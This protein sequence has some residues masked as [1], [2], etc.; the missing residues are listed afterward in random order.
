MRRNSGL[1]KYN[2]FAGNTPRVLLSL[3]LLMTA[4]PSFGAELSIQFETI[5]RTNVT[6]I[7]E[8]FGA[9]GG[10]SEAPVIDSEGNIAFVGGGGF[11]AN[12]NLQSGI[13]TLTDGQFQ[14]VADKNTLVPGGGGTKFTTFYGSDLN[15]IDAGRV[16]FRAN[17]VSSGTLLGIYSNAGQASPA[18]LVELALIDGTEWTESSHP[19]ID[20]NVVA[21]RG[22]SPDEQTEM[23]HWDGSSLSTS[24][25][26]PGT[27][28]IIS[29]ASQASISGD[30]TIFRRYK[31]GSSQMVISHAGSIEALATLDSTAIPGQ[32]G[33]VFSNFNFFPVVGNGGQDAAFRGRGGGVIGVY[34]RTNDGALEA[35]ADS[36][37]VAPGTANNAF[38]YFDDSGISLAGGQ[39]VFLG[40]GSSFLDGLYTDIGGGLSLI[41]DDQN[42]N[43]ISLDGQLEQVSDIRFSSKS[44]ADTP[45][46]YQVVFR[47]ALQSGGTAII[48]ATINTGTT[49]SAP[50]ITV[51]GSGSF[52]S[53]EIGS[54]STHTM[55]VGN[56]GDANLV[57]GNLYGLAAPF[58]I[59]SDGCSGATVAPGSTCGISVRFRPT[60]TAT[61]ADT[62]FIPSNDPDQ[63]T[64]NANFNGNG[65]SAPVPDIAVSG[66][67]SFGNVEIGSSATQ[68]LTV[69][70]AGDANLVIG[71]LFGLAA[72]FTIMTDSCTGRTL[73]P[74][75][76]CGIS[77]QFTPTTTATS[78]DT[79]VIP[80]NDPVEANFTASYSGSGTSAPVPDI[81]VS[82][83]GAMGDV[84]IGSSATQSLTISNAGDAN[85]VIDNLYGLVA[86]FS[87]VSD[88]CSGTTLT[89]AGSCT[90]SVRFAPSVTGLLSDTLV[91]PSNDP[92]QANYF[93]AFNGRGTAALVPDITVSGNG[94]FGNVEIGTSRT[95]SLTVSSSGTANLVIGNVYGLANPFTI[96]SD[97]CTGMTLAPSTSCGIS[98]LYTPTTPSTSTDTLV[99]PSNDPIEVS[100]NVAFNGT[101]TNAPEP[102]ISVSG[103]S[104]FGDVETGTSSNRSFTISNTGDANLVIDN[105]YGLAAPFSRV[106]DNCTGQTLAPAASCTLGVRFAPTSNG[107]QNDT[108]MIPSNDPVQNTVN[109]NLNGNGTSPSTAPDIAVSGNGA[110][111]DVETG[112]SSTLNINISNSGDADLLVGNLYGLADPFSTVTDSCSGKTLTPNG[113][114]TVSV[115]FAPTSTG[116]QND[117]LMIPSNDPVQAIVSFNLNGNGTSAPVPNIAVSGNGSLGDVET[118]SSSATS[119]TIN[120]NGD[121]NLVIGNLYGL[122]APF[123]T[124]SDGCSGATLTPAGSC[125]VSVNFA[126]TVDGLQS[127]TLVIPSNDPDKANYFFAFNGNGTTNSAADIT[128][129]GNGAFGDVEVDSSSN[130][131]VTIGNAGDASLVIGNL[132][133]LAAPFSILTDS[134]SGA[135]LAPADTCTVGVQFAPTTTGLLT[136]KLVIPSSDPDQA[137]FFYSVSGN[138]TETPSSGDEV[139]IISSDFETGSANEWLLNGAIAVDGTESIGQYSL[140]HRKSGTSM[141]RVSTEGYSGVSV[142]MHLAATSLEQDDG[143][144]AEIS[145]NGG[146]SWTSVVE[147]HDGNDTG[148]F[149]SGTVTP[150]GANN[151]SD[152][153]LRFRSTGQHKPDYCWGDAVTVTGIPSEDISDF[154]VFK[155][156]SDDNTGSVS[157]SLSCSSGLVTNNPQL[158]SEVSPAIFVIEGAG[159]GATY[160]ADETDCQDGDPLNG[161]C[162]IV[163]TIVPAQDEVIV[164]ENF[165]DGSIG[166]WTLDGNVTTDAILAIGNFSLRHEQGTA[167]E[168]SI[169]T[170]GYENVSVTMHLAATSLKQ[171]GGC[172]AEVSTDSG[173]TWIPVFDVLK[174]ND[175]GVFMSGTVSPA[176]AIDNLDLRLRFRSVTVRGKG[177][178]CYG[179]DVI[180]T[181]TPMGG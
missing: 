34:K 26:N 21:M 9:F 23:L 33:L 127:D 22:K 171:D 99:I 11:D 8:G 69:S 145:T 110:F 88:G 108:L 50:D 39:I 136:D 142:K 148:E 119:L 31:T 82:G 126:P 7:P 141:L 114:C 24:F 6:P 37:T 18:D 15:D 170:A 115:S 85:L 158:A 42:N 177:G 123:S 174:G 106:S 137:N 139:V 86:P 151:N 30:A 84:E 175:N 81:A 25:L 164:D 125:T 96:V 58:S 43:T 143:C 53:V 79:L 163:N 90:V 116:Q 104:N 2:F 1:S 124:S 128:V 68:S 48:K 102:N 41:V 66:S 52:G 60:T 47:A 62:L 97:G 155:D 95:H 149:F 16:A 61:S 129:S 29:P 111:G 78:S 93:F 83:N 154:T 17:T 160:T 77:V 130:S 59:V 92:D 178:Y 5:A 168:L 65:T 10:L 113:S 94:A 76:S 146:D 28:Y 98:V 51:S 101:G 46:G 64:I 55:S 3:L 153:R 38:T 181:G 150:T 140:R 32:P 138:G 36:T 131:S 56:A 12:G 45:D 112:S 44:F 105:T 20:G 54:S 180:V 172:Y 63:A 91:F 89:P 176:D 57:I 73:A 134:C 157:V 118:D 162:T 132:Y 49:T 152:L 100:F 80:S 122:A 87:T 167:S 75:A 40:M 156:F 120:N 19:W 35:V 161:S 147:V 107:Q 14:K 117:T 27:G 67:G 133:G 169:S 13:Y 72:P 135:T 103:N 144:Y 121:A 166:D 165:E 179:D 74:A 173:D 71:N 159:T 70:N 4:A 109:L